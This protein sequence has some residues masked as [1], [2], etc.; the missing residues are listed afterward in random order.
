MK[1]IYLIYQHC[2]EKHLHRYHAEFDFRYSQRVRLGVTWSVPDALKGI[3]GLS[4]RSTI[5]IHP[6][7]QFHHETFDNLKDM[8]G[9]FLCIFL[10]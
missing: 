4:F 3:V 9:F 6:I 10:I 7:R 1:G 2:S 8:F 5:L